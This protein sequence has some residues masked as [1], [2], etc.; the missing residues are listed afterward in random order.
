MDAALTVFD[1]IYSDLL[2]G[3]IYAWVLLCITLFMIA[4]RYQ[5]NLIRQF[6]S[7]IFRIFVKKQKHE[8]TELI[9][10]TLMCEVNSAWNIEYNLDKG[11]N[12]LYRWIVCQ[13]FSLIRDNVKDFYDDYRSGRVSPET[14]CNPAAHRKLFDKIKLQFKQD[15]IRKLHENDWSDEKIAILRESTTQWFGEHAKLFDKYLCVCDLPRQ[16]MQNWLW[17]VGETI[18]SAERYGMNLNGQIKDLYFE[19]IQ[20]LTNQPLTKE[21]RN[22]RY[23]F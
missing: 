2:C 22:D 20:I 3:N 5:Q 6:F 12:C 17:L 7:A 23:I 15:F 11:R 10:G 21:T 16:F 4:W 1:R 19:G 18:T 9:L 8:H 14:F 13:L